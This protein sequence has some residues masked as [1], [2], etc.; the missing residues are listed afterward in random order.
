M[1]Y[2]EEPETGNVIYTVDRLHS[3]ELGPLD[4]KLWDEPAYPGAKITVLLQAETEEKLRGY[5][6]YLFSDAEHLAAKCQIVEREP[7]LEQQ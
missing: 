7:S 1:Y 2:Y 4:P 3:F 5:I 6:E